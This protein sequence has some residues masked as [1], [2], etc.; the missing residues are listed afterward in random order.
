[1]QQR[2]RPIILTVLDGWGYRANPEFNAIAAA[3]KPNWDTLWAT[4]PHTLISGSG[5]CVGLPDGQM[6]NSEVGH[7]NLGLGRVVFQDLTRISDAIETGTFFTNPVFLQ[8]IQQAKTTNRAIHIIGLLS[9]GGVHSHEDHICALLKLA[10]AQGVEQLFL[11]ALLDGRDTPPKSATASLAKI[12]TVLQAQKAGKIAS[13]CGRYYAMDRD[14]RWERV[15]AAYDMLTSGKTLYHATSA[16][17][18]LQAAYLRNETDEFVQPTLIDLPNRPGLIETGDIVI[19][20]NFR[21]DRTRELSYALVQPDFTGFSRTVWPQL[22]AFVT[23]TEYAKD[24]PAWVAY[25]PQSLRNGLG[26]FLSVQNFKQLRIAET[27]KYAHVTFFFNGGVESEYT[28]EER[29]LL[30]SP[31]VA[32]YDLQPE[33]SAEALTDQLITAIHS[34]KYDFIVCNFANA[35]MVGHSG[36]FD[37]TKQAIEAIDRCLGRIV[38]AIRQVN[39][40][41]L[42]TADHGNAEY[43]YDK[44]THQVHTAHT[45]EP[46]PLIYIGRPAHFMVEDGK[47]ADIAPTLLYLMNLS[48]PVEMTGRVLLTLG[49]Q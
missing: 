42:I 45:S 2:P 16:E 22:G 3:D 39:G 28:G 23:L 24:L 11:H 1:M 8:A 30:P 19:F 32:T 36:N 26:E 13:I 5:H 17:A 4:C 7:M 33:M 25:P 21:T 27:E 12:E 10:A 14:Q 31:K 40:E 49:E 15:Q 29:I 38:H 44:K 37:A 20:M 35:D 43:M 9:P 46:V 41:M 18:A 48:I 47:L 6:G 34:G